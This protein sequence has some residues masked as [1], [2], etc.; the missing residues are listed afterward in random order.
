MLAECLVEHYERQLAQNVTVIA[1]TLET[2]EKI[3]DFTDGDKLQL[4][5]EINS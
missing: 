1:D 2:L 5:E 3:E 4:K